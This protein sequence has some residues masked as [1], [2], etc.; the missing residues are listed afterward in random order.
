MRE[1][2]RSQNDGEG[3]GVVGE[4]EEKR[5][6]CERDRR[7]EVMA[8]ALTCFCIHMRDVC[9]GRDDR[10][11]VYVVSNAVARGVPGHAIRTIHLGRLH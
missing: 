10:R 3:V 11:D 9:G 1:G 7:R 4:G 6:Q 2:E 5:G 8:A